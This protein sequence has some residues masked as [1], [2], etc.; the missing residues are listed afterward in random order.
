MNGYA[1]H[2]DL[3][4]WELL[5]SSDEDSFTEIYRRYSG[6][7]FLHAVRILDSDEEAKDIVQDLFTNLWI[8]RKDLRP[9][10][11]LSAYLFTAV[12]NRVLD[13]IARR[14]TEKRSLASLAQFLEEGVNLTDQ[15]IRQKELTKIIEREVSL[16]PPRMREIFERSRRDDQ[17]H[18][19]I[20][21]ELHISD[22]TVKKQVSNALIILR[23]KID[24]VLSIL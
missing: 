19:E 4:L 20:A 22:K 12:R 23:R 24:T 17:S 11:S 10:N 3:E 7:L 6:V 9:T 13:Y 8:R 15:E 5:Q 21:Q 16:L 14:E 1:T 2:T 18:K